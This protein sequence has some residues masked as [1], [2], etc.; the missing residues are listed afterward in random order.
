MF[1]TKNRRTNGAAQP[2]ATERSE[3]AA[4]GQ[5]LKI[6]TNTPLAAKAQKRTFRPSL[7]TPEATNAE[8]VR[9]YER[10]DVG[11]TYEHAIPR[12]PL[13]GDAVGPGETDA[14]LRPQGKGSRRRK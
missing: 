1:M 7:P 10:D 4:M 12:G 11:A 14:E 9:R 6:P 13:M 2:N 3:R 8:F 5:Q